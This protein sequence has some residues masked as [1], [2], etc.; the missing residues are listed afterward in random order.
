MLLSHRAPSN[1]N[2]SSYRAIWTHFRQKFIFVCKKKSDP[3]QKILEF[4]WDSCSTEVIMDHLVVKIPLIWGFRSAWCHDFRRPDPG[5]ERGEV[6]AEGR[7]HSLDRNVTF[8]FC[9]CHHRL[10]SHQITKLETL[11]SYGGYFR[12][13]FG[14]SSLESRRGEG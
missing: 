7:S 3:G 6:F 5:S 9:K 10:G 11:V 4:S 8:Q 13:V 12:A 14:N 1:L 2:M